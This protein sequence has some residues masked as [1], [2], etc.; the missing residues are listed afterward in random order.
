MNRVQNQWRRRRR[1]IGVYIN[2]REWEGKAGKIG[3]KA[4]QMSAVVAKRK[5]V[6]RSVFEIVNARATNKSGAVR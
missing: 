6:S 5:R 3:A 1:K 2:K 4:K